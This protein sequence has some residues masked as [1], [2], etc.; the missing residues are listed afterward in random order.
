[1]EKYVKYAVESAMLLVR[2]VGFYGMEVVTIARHEQGCR[3][4]SMIMTCRVAFCFRESEKT[5]R[6]AREVE[7]GGREGGDESVNRRSY[8]VCMAVPCTA[9][10]IRTVLSS[11]PLHTVPRTEHSART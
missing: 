1:M 10:Q 2:S 4:R 9:S 11:P 5:P 6:R 8:S 3:Q 7:E